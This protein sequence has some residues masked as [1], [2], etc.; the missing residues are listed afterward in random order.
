[1]YLI[2]LRQLYTC[3]IIKYYDYMIKTENTIHGIYK[4]T[5]LN[6]KVDY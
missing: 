4:L 6:T 3:Q 5:N 1:M 2:Q